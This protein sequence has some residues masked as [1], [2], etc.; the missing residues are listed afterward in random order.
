MHYNLSPV[1]KVTGSE[2]QKYNHTEQPGRDF[3]TSLA[4]EMHS[5]VDIQ[6]C[7]IYTL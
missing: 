1:S 2:T 4:I 6:Y 3:N 5:Q 7:S